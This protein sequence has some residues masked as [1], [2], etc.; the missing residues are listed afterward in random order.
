MK[1]VGRT[2]FIYYSIINLDLTNQIKANELPTSVV[3]I[4]TNVAQNNS[5]SDFEFCSQISQK[6]AFFTIKN[7]VTNR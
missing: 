4:E 2:I 6:C 3:F 5:E 7:R 1:I